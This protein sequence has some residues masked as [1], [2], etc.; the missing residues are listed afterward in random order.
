MIISSRSHQHPASGAN[1]PSDVA[2]TVNFHPEITL[3]PVNPII[4]Y[5]SRDLVPQY[6]QV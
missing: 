5:F 2:V 6:G 3:M 1:R 4:E